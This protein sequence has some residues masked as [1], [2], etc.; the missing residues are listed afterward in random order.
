MFR[1]TFRESP[2]VLL[3]VLIMDTCGSS[4]EAVTSFSFFFP[5]VLCAYHKVFCIFE[6]YKAKY[7][8]LVIIL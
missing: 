7:F 1:W 2:R 3:A 8:I 5:H 6:W 4:V